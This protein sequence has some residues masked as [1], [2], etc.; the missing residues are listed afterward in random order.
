MGKIIAI[1][2]RKGGVGKTTTAIN[3]GAALARKGKRVLLVDLDQQASMSKSL[4]I[5]GAD[6]TVYD[7][8]AKGR[9]AAEA[10]VRQLDY[11]IIPADD[12]LAAADGELAN[13]PGREFIL[14]EALE[15]I[16]AEYDF[17]LLDCPPG[18]GLMTVNALVAADDLYI[19]L[20]ATP[21]SLEGLAALLDV[22]DLVQ[23]RLN[24][25][26]RMAGVIITRYSGRLKVSRE[27]M[28]TIRESF[29][30]AIFSTPIRENVTLSEAPGHG[31]D[32]FNYD[33]KSAGAQDYLAIADEIILREG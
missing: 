15:P 5:R 30:A 4:G 10:I 1:S 7:V 3:I 24:K 20:E 13:E 28:E 29:P 27:I 31:L 8:M 12:D 14:R 16:R 18:L 32:I 21:M 26:L 17:I 6:S 22:V 11:D 25:G 2:N 19:P 9:K 23:R 33:P